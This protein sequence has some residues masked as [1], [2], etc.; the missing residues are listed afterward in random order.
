M[1]FRLQGASVSNTA[2]A[3]ISASI[4]LHTHARF[5]DPR[6]HQK[7]SAYVAQVTAHKTKAAAEGHV[8][9]QYW[10]GLEPPKALADIL[11]AL[12]GAIYLSDASDLHGVQRFFDRVLRPFYDEHVTLHTLSDHPHSA[13]TQVMQSYPCRE[14]KVDSSSSSTDAN[15]LG[16]HRCSGESSLSLSPW[17][18]ANADGCSDCARRRS[19]SC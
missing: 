12:I 11:E 9:G 19:R 15:S 18:G 7:V 8:I 6:T 5:E 16:S 10:I 1:A 3:A 17:R 13:L 14:F 2:L 4:G